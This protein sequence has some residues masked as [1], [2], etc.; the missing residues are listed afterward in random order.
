MYDSRGV[1]DY[2]CLLD[3]N[4]KDRTREGYTLYPAGAKFFAMSF[5][6]PKARITDEIE[7]TDEQLQLL[8]ENHAEVSENG[9]RP[10]LQTG[11]YFRHELYGEQYCHDKTYIKSDEQK[12]KEFKEQGCTLF[13]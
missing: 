13:L 4:C 10:V 3:S 1:L 5:K 9:V 7:V 12:I 6:I 8:L 11:H 2:V